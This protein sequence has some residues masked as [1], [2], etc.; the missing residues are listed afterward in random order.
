MRPCQRTKHSYP[1]CWHVKH[2]RALGDIEKKNGSR[3][4]AALARKLEELVWRCYRKIEFEKLKYS[5]WIRFQNQF[6][7]LEFRIRFDNLKVWNPGNRAAVKLESNLW[8]SQIWWF[9]QKVEPVR[10]SFGICQIRCKF[11][12]ALA[13]QKKTSTNT[14][15]ASMPA[16]QPAANSL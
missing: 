8:I 1:I 3:G 10:T 4:N 9:A 11:I 5:E 16:R 7:S 14:G 13:W 12:R 2:S 15:Y 6:C